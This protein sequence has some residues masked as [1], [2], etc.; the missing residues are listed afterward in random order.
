MLKGKM[1]KIS[2]I[3]LLVIGIMVVQQFGVA[4]TSS[5]AYATDDIVRIEIRSIRNTK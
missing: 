2:I 3:T 4:G 1:K 5:V